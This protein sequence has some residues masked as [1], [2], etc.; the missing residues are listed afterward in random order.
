MS[1]RGIDAQIMIARAPDFVKEANAQLKGAEKMQEFLAA[2]SK[3]EAER[4][5]SSV[6]KAEKTLQVELH[7]DADGGGRGQY[8]SAREKKFK[9]NEEATRSLL[10]ADVGSAK[11][12]IDIKF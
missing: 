3:A 2:Q 11:N 7:P 10:D 12:L 4:E 1:I 8:E 9:E 5:K 6:A